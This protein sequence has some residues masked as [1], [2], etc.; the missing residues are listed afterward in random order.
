MPL[1]GK[2]PLIAGS[3]HGISRE[4]ALKLAEKGVKVPL[5]PAS[6][7]RGR[8]AWLRCAQTMPMRTAQRAWTSSAMTSAPVSRA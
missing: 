7:S 6:W 5:H 8:L 2:L 1:Q 3:S 4:I